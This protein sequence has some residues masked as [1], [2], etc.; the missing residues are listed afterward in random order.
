MSCARKRL[1]QLLMLGA[2]AVGVPIL[3]GATSAAASS[4]RIAVGAAARLPHGARVG[5][6][7]PAGRRLRLTLALQAKSSAALTAFATAVSTPGNPQYGQYLSVSQFA[8]RFGATSSQIAA[9]TKTMRAAGLS[10]GTATANHL[11]IPVTGTAAQVQKAFSVTESQVTLP[12]GRVAFAN[13]RAPV[14]SAGIAHVVQGVIGLD[15]LSVPH[16]QGLSSPHMH[17]GNARPHVVTGGPQPC[18][19]ASGSGGYTADLI[20]TAYQLPPI[21]QAGNLGQGQT[22]AVF[23][24]QPFDP[25]DIAAYQA[26]YGTAASVSPVT[27]GIGPGTDIPGSTDDSEAALDIEMVVGLAPKASVLVY[28]GPPTAAGTVAIMNQMASDNKAKVISSSWGACESATGASVIAADDTA[29]KEM[30]AQGQSFFI[31]SGDSGS[32]MCSQ[33]GQGDDSLSVISPGSDPFATAVGGTTLFSVTGAGPVLYTGGTAVE[34]VWNDSTSIEGASGGGIAT[35]FAMPAYQSAANGALGIVDAH[36]SGAQCGSTGPCREVPDVSADADPETGYAVFATG[37]SGPGWTTIGGTSAAAPMWGAFMALVN[38]NA[39]CRGQTIGFANPSLYAIAQSAYT[40]NFRDVALA[41][42]VSTEANNDYTGDNGGLY[43]V[44]AGYDLATGLGSP[45][46]STLAASLCALRSP[47]YTVSVASPGN[48]LTVR[49]T[50]VSV[51]VNAADSGGAGLGYAA[52][53]LPAG[54]SINPSTGVISGTATTQQNTTV[55]VSAGDAFT[56]AGSTSFTWSV[57]V[58]GKPQAKSPKFSGLG[59]G[60]PKLTFTVSSGSFAPALKSVQIKLPGGLSFAQKAKSLTKGITV[61]S[62]SKKVKFSAKTKGGGLLITFKSAVTTATVT[63]ARPAISIS[64]AEANKVRHHKVKKLSVS[65]KAT[66]ASHKTT[67]FS[68]TIKKPS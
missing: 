15:N 48:Q 5:H 50:A 19:Q 57:V 67:S 27:V 30:A 60:K 8:Q 22:V 20:A 63:L 36:N 12:G 65:F 68:A 10:V 28:Q 39:A 47:V 43:P 49:G 41:S 35:A 66:D 7:L 37:G 46:G 59:K 9:V 56:N 29:L 18:S 55:T 23:E 6:A 17:R 26:C 45:L 11:S 16:P 21:Y 32:E 52:S 14:L 1:V 33:L 3:L 62:G 34:G 25:S 2:T 64:S 40:T 24:Q 44:K 42:P 13:D 4:P 38:D 61:K 53:G 54:L 31:S 58:P 51:A